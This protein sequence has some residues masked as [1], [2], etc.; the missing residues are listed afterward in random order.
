MTIIIIIIQFYI[1]PFRKQKRK[2]HIPNHMRT[3]FS[4]TQS[5]KDI[6]RKLYINLKY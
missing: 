1:S 3:A 2:E 5:D 4:F 6:A